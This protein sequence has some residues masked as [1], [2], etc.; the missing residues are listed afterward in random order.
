MGQYMEP[1]SV[2]GTGKSLKKTRQWERTLTESSENR[3]HKK[4]IQ[5]WQ[6]VKE[7]GDEEKPT[8]LKKTLL[9]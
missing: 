6:K 7:S 4:Q 5:I 8:K 3:R 1:G 2:K 9:T